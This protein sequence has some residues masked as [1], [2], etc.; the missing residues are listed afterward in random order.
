MIVWGGVIETE[1]GN[2]YCASGQPNVAPVAS[3]DVYNARVGKQIT[4]SQAAGVLANDTDANGD[5]LI[6]R[7][8]SKPSHGRLTFYANGSFVYKSMKGFVGV[9]TF[10]YQANDGIANSNTATVAITVQ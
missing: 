7:L 6:A 5:F 8:V 10:A 3:D 4:I 2:L 1:R 9:D